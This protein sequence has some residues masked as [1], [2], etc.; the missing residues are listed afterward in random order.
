MEQLAPGLTHRL[1]S[2][3]EAPR[4]YVSQGRGLGPSFWWGRPVFFVFSFC[5]TIPKNRGIPCHKG[6][7]KEV[8]HDADR[9]RRPCSVSH[10]LPT[11]VSDGIRS[12]TRLPSRA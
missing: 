2:H 4:W 1:Y 3:K 9:A 6:K 7:R 12:W 11:R 8:I 10:P 5:I